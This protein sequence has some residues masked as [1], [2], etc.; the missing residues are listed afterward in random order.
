MQYLN[1][2][3][4]K[5]P[6]HRQKITLKAMDVVLFGPPKGNYTLSTNASYNIN[7]KLSCRWSVV[8]EGL[9]VDFFACRW[10]HW[11]VVCFATKQKIQKSFKPNE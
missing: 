8:L 6:I 2:L 9:N 11:S 4:I 7:F 1:N 3:G 10:Q 5:D